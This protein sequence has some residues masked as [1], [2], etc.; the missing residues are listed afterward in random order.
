[1]TRFSPTAR[2]PLYDW[3]TRH[4]A[5]LTLEHG[6]QVPAAYT[7]AEREAE[8]ARNGVAVADV[9]AFRKWSLRGKHLPAG[10]PLSVSVQS[11]VLACRL[12]PDHLLLLSLAMTD[13]AQCPD[14][15]AQAAVTTDVT[16]AHAGFLFVGPRVEELL[17]RLTALDVR[18]AAFPV[19]TCAETNVAGVEALLVRTPEL[20]F[21][22]YVPWD[23]GEYVWER[24][25]EAGRELAI[26]P[27]G[28]EGLRLLAAHG[29]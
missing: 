9:S 12:T 14:V 20:A 27:L 1:M 23:A 28:M 7:A 11:G 5:R 4:G 25:M 17:H 3:H 18:L 19:C 26:T 15:S 29:K 8:A 24:I 16:S 2:T 6:W 21:R 13:N 10:N 22:V